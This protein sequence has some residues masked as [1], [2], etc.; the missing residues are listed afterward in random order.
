MEV[1]ADHEN[2]TRGPWPL[3][4]ITRGERPEN[5]L[6][7]T[8]QANGFGALVYCG[9]RERNRRTGIGG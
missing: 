9:V 5:I 6:Q 2:R 1:G 4:G 8:R 7:S 3:D